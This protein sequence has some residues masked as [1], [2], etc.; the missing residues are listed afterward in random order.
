MKSKQ[1]QEFKETEI[2]KIPVDWNAKKLIDIAEKKSDIVAG[3][4]GSDLVVK[5]Y[6][7][8]GIPIIRIQ[9]IERYHFKKQGIKF[10]DEIKY[11]ELKYHSFKAGD[12]VLAKLGDPIGKTCI[13]PNDLLKGI[14]TADI[15][16]IRIPCTNMDNRFLLYILNSDNIKISNA[17]QHACNQ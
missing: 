3:P 14:V 9:N 1:V 8:Q 10:I 11:N 5:D 15:V 13:V 6:R 12:I 16:R 2:G 4:F 17:I 7:P